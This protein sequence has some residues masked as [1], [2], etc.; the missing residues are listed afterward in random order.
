VMMAPGGGGI[1]KMPDT[2]EKKM[3]S[4]V[5]AMVRTSAEKN[6]Y[7]IAVVEAMIDKDKGLTIDDQVIAKEGE[8]LTLTNTEAEKEYGTPPKALLSSGT[9]E[10]MDQLLKKLDF[11]DAEQHRIRVTG[12]EKLAMWLN[13]I[14]PLLLI[15]G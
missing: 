7:S 9:V 10:S 5:K 14:S 3:I 11:A 6:G 8:I 1:E 13:L 4:A 15:F 2:Y 12:M